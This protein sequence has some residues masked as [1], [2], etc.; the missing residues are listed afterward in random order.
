M[1][2]ENQANRELEFQL[3]VTRAMLGTLELDQILYIILS[4]I[5]HGD[6]LGFNRA[7][8]FLADEGRRELRATTAVGPVDEKQAHRIWEEM[9]RSH[10]DLPTLLDS[11]EQNAR[12]SEAGDLTARLAGFSMPLSVSA[13]PLD[14]ELQLMPLQAIIA[15]C[16]DS[17]K[18]FYSNR[19]RAV[20]EPPPATGVQVLYYEKLACAP[21]VHNEEVIGVILADNFFSKKDV[22]EKKLRGLST[23]ANL[24][25]IAIER[26][27]LYRRIQEMAAQDGLTG[28]A[29]RR[30][31]EQ[32]LEQ[33]MAR[34]RRTRRPLSLIIFDIDDFKKCNDQYGH[35]CGDRVLKD[36]ATCLR[37]RVRGE[38]L[39]A[40]YGG[41][42]FVIMLTGSATRNEAYQVAEKL[43][44]FVAAQSLGG[45]PPG[46]VTISGGVATMEAEDLDISPLFKLADRALY[47]AKAQGKNCVVMGENV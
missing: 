32:R 9:E 6:G 38:D 4:C 17:K 41:E 14:D 13:P 24:A 5:T 39:V 12:R 31:Y 26:A 25:A 33:E 37:S 7:F 2:T 10:L 20:F 28:L 27:R 18:P 19:L 15:N 47:Q 45:L 35:E 36:L 46:Q 42:E 34:S 8:L 21:L 43:R 44:Q 30:H 16:M 3:Q 29:N 22:D 23:M 11:Y 40:R 1:S